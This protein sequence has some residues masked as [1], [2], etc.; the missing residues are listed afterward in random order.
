MIEAVLVVDDEPL[1]R[2]FLKET[3]QRLNCQVDLKDNGKDAIS[4]FKDGDT[5]Y[6]LVFLDMKLP[7]ATG[8]EVLK[9]IKEQSPSTEV[10][11]ITAY[12]TIENAVD[13]MKLG[14][15]DYLLKPFTPD[16][17]ELIFERINQKNILVEENQYL[18]GE[19]NKKYNFSEIVGD[20]QHM[21]KIFE[22]IKKVAIST[23]TV[24]ISGESGTGKELIARAIT[25]NGLRKE[26]PFIKVNCASLP[27]TLLE[28]ELFG[29]ERGAFTGA[30]Q[31]RKG[32]FELADK[33]TLLLDEIGEITLAVQAKLL[34]VLQEREFERVGGARPIKV[35]V[36]VLATTNKD[37]SKEIEK[38][39]FREDL[40]YRLNVVPIQV[41]PLRKRKKDIALLVNHFLEKFT[42]FSSKEMPDISKSTME[43]FINYSWPG[44]V[45]ELEN[46]IERIIVLDLQ[47]K[48]L[49]EHLDLV[50]A[51]SKP[52]KD[53]FKV[54]RR[55]DDIEKDYILKTLAHMGNNKSKTAEVLDISVRTLRNKLNAYGIREES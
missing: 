1:M 10:I 45:R 19:I 37:L 41:C 29:H 39:N 44:N 48:E 22:T 28:S 14:A 53:D 17:V 33:G 47:G 11:V 52:G 46:I 51:S 5:S 43:R 27:E 26:K 55:M 30:I 25:Y 34:R 21:A 38:G 13:A 31:R 18:R 35:D 12:G 3:L 6:D 36:R 9:V 8:T 7:G 32:R 23:A 24:L 2:D 49:D 40:F 50:L 16:Q 54:G 15:F 4:L 42:H 20:S